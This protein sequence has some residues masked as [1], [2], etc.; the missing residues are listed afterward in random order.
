MKRI[1]ILAGEYAPYS[2]PCAFRMRSFA[3]YLPQYGYS[4]TIFSV[5]PGS[6]LLS[7][8]SYF[9]RTALDHGAQDICETYRFRQRRRIHIPSPLKMLGC[10]IGRGHHSK[11]YVR[12]AVSLHERMPFDVIL[13]THPQAGPTLWAGHELKERL[14]L[15]LIIDFRDIAEEFGGFLKPQKMAGER[16]KERLLRAFAKVRH[17][18]M[19]VHERTAAHRADGVITVSDG[20][21][22]LMCDQWRIPRPCVVI[23]GFAPDDYAAVSP[24]RFDKFTLLYAGAVHHQRDLSSLLEALRLLPMRRRDLD[25][26]VQLILLGAN[27]IVTQRYPDIATTPGIV[28]QTRV[29]KPEAISHMLGADMLIHLSHPGT[30]GVMTS[31]LPEYLA[32]RKPILTIPG[33]GDVVEAILKETGAGCALGQAEDIAQHIINA[34]DANAAGKDMTN[35]ADLSRYTRE[36]Q[37]QILAEYMENV[38]AT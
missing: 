33:D 21:A 9:T 23:N 28:L 4:P 29:P 5:W 12:Q 38:L 10:R 26:K 35:R 36:H 18:R 1:L 2:T 16:L 31:K 27:K 8:H 17:E 25:G 24:K 34:Y 15:P 20:L 11:T 6:E 3:K 30:T 13:A 19:I 7:D 32:A 22:N 14:G 37:C